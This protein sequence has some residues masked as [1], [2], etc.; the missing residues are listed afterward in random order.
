MSGYGGRVISSLLLC[1]RSHETLV[2][3][4]IGSPKA[5]R[6][7]SLPRPAIAWSDLSNPSNVRPI[8]IFI[9]N[10]VCEQ[11]LWRKKKTF[12]LTFICPPFN[13][14]AAGFLNSFERDSLNDDKIVKLSLIAGEQRQ[15]C[16]IYEYNRR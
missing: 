3:C 13:F 15:L 7:E 4:S 10:S 1:M 16:M 8:Y 11:K 5:L 12:S 6:A 14:S 2:L 9:I